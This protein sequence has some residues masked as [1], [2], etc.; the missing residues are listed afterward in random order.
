MN[1]EEQP[2]KN[3]SID[4]RLQKLKENADSDSTAIGA[5]SRKLEATHGSRRS[6]RRLKRKERSA[7]EAGVPEL[8]EAQKQ[9]LERA[10]RADISQREATAA[11]TEQSATA[12]DANDPSAMVTRER[13]ERIRKELY[14]DR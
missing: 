10:R 7:N 11:V 13:L 2:P 4:E 3:H 8:L 1:T 5:R 6:L 12:A 9:A 14:R